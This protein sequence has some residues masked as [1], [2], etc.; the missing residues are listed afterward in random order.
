MSQSHGNKGGTT[1]KVF[2]EHCFLGE[3]GASVGVDPDILNFDNL[4]QKK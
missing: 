4:L 1:D 2:Q 3:R